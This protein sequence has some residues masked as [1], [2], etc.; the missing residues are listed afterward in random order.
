MDKLLISLKE[1]LQ[2][3]ISYSGGCDLESLKKC[4]FEVVKG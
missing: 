2:S 3:A 4:D 1:D